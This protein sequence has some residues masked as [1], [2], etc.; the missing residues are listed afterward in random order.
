MLVDHSL[1]R[2]APSSASVDASSSRVCHALRAPALA[3]AGAGE[4][5]E[6]TANEDAA[7][8]EATQSRIAEIRAQT[9]RET[10]AHIARRGEIRNQA[11][12]KIVEIH[13]ETCRTGLV[14][15]DDANFNPARDIGMG[16]ERLQR[17]RE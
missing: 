10:L 12:K 13:D 7:N 2:S 15:T 4:R 6:W 14:L 11:N 17:T 3:A 16:G 1:M 9:S 8:K 5:H